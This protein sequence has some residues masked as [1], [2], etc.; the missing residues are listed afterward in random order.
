MNTTVTIPTK[1]L[2]P[3]GSM[4]LA[5]KP[6]PPINQPLF[7]KPR[8][9]SSS[10]FCRP[11]TP[12]PSVR[13]TSG[14]AQRHLRGE[15]A[16]QKGLGGRRVTGALRLWYAAGFANVGRQPPAARHVHGATATTAAQEDGLVQHLTV[17]GAL[18][19]WYAAV[20]S[21][22][23]A[24]VGRQPPAARHVHGATATTAAQ[25]DGLIQHLT[26]E[27]GVAN[28]GSLAGERGSPSCLCVA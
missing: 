25:E 11:P 10:G 5:K 20:V 9:V 17:T 1:A 4:A 3:I 22:G 18:R 28:L 26:A 14:H 27:I 13:S 21:A 2:I 24:N 19:L 15:T 8:L 12:L 6:R 7:V 16:A 23:L